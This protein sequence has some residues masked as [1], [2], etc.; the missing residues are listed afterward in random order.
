MRWSLVR[1]IF[2]QL[3]FK[4]DSQRS[5]DILF[6][7]LR[8]GFSNLNCLANKVDYVTSLIYDNELD[9]FGVVETWL[10]PGICDAAVSAGAAQLFVLIQQE[11]TPNIEFY[12]M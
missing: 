3:V 5:A 2:C 6:Y 4:M 11:S 1:K 8:L 10:L 9:I 7:D 12:F